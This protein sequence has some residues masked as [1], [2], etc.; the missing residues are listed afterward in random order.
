ML[1]M[2]AFFCLICECSLFSIS[3]SG[4]GDN[5]QKK[6]RRDDQ[7]EKFKVDINFAA[8]IPMKSLEAVLRGDLSDKCQD[9]LRVL[10][11]ILRQHAARKYVIT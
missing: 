5:G 1:I 2:H 10:D 11:I 6:M 7:A 9:A 3:G 8:K 4:A